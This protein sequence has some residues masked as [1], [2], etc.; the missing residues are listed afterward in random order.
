MKRR[1][2]I[3]RWEK[4]RTTH[5]KDADALAV[6]VELGVMQLALLLQTVADEPLGLVQVTG[7][8]AVPCC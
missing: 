5:V 8:F 6:R 7:R 3:V 1:Q 2:L 4:K